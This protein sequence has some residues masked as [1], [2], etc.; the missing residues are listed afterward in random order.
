MDAY[1]IMHEWDNATGKPERTDA[2]LDR[3]IP[4]LL[5][6]GDYETWK[7]ALEAG[8]VPAIREGMTIWGLPIEPLAAFEVDDAID[9]FERRMEVLRPDSPNGGDKQ[10]P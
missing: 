1:D 7:A 2:E 3:D 5:K 10:T 8:N 9:T 4:G 6:S